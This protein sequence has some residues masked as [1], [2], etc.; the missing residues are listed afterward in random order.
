MTQLWHRPSV[1]VDQT[2]IDSLE[3]WELLQAEESLESQ[4]VV[5][6]ASILLEVATGRP[7]A[8]ASDSDKNAWPFFHR[9]RVDWK[10]KTYKDPSDPS[11]ELEADDKIDALGF[12]DRKQWDSQQGEYIWKQVPSWYAATVVAAEGKRLLVQFHNRAKPKVATAIAAAFA[13][14]CRANAK[15]ALVIVDVQDCFLP[16][17]S[18]AVTGADRIIPHI[19]NMAQNKSC[20]FDLV[21][22]TQDFHPSNHI[23]FGSTHGLPAFSDLPTSV[24][25]LGKGELALTCLKPTTGSTADASCC[26][27]Y[28]LNPSSFDCTTQLC[29]GDGGTWNYSVNMSAIVT[30]NTACTVCAQ[31]PDSC[32]ATTQRMWTDHCEQ[33]GDTTFPS[34]LDAITGATLVQKGSNR[35]VDAYSAFMDNSR[36]LQ[37]TLDAT[38]QAE[39]ISRIFVTGIATDVCVSYT[40][41]DALLNT[42]GAYDVIVV[43]DA[44]AGLFPNTEAAALAEFAQL[45]GVTVMNTTDVL[46]MSCPTTT[47]MV[48]A[49][50][51]VRHIFG[52]AAIA[53]A[54]GL[55]SAS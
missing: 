27:T 18:L 5:D 28:H 26:P 21:V 17:G 45:D 30:G 49:S 42:T 7:V 35:F 1:E 12:E 31:T 46:A 50:G 3:G 37:T 34:G 54:L 20:L 14:L 48:D 16:G 36:N 40:V 6:G 44:T 10:Q 11:V 24:G 25:G 53:M 9:L 32:F 51:T 47:T 43:G 19:L 22:R 15:S 4:A 2:R 41:K 52:L 29:P 23:S 8:S 33:T 13:A 39:G 38:L 55:G